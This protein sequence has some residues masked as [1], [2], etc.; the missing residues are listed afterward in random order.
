MSNDEITN[1]LTVILIAM[2]V[3]LFILVVVYLV[4]RIKTNKPQ[5]REEKTKLDSKQ[6]SKQSEI[7]TYNKQSIFSFMKFD[8]IEDNMIVRRNG[9]KFLMLIECQGINYD[10]MSGLEKNSVEQGFLQFLNTLRYPIQ[11]YVQTRTVNL[12]SGIIKYKERVKEI[13]DRLIKKQ[14]E[15]NRKES[16]GYALQ[17]INKARLDVTRERNLYEYGIDIINNTEKMSLNK[18]ILRKHYYVIIDY[19][20]EEINTNSFGKEEI[21]S[22]AFS[23]LYTKAQ[24]IINALAVCGVNGKILNSEELAELL[25]VA[26]NRDESEV[27][28]LEKA[29]NAGYDELYST[30][31]DVLDKRM[32]ELDKKVEYEAKKLANET[33]MEVMEERE[34][35]RRVKQ[36]EAEMDEL[37]R[38]MASYMVE[39]NE[40]LIGK[41]VADAAKSKINGEEKVEEETVKTTTRRRG[42]KKKIT[43]EEEGINEEE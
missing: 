32:K 15:L 29:L 12:E 22:M 30:A 21:S 6:T 38:Q 3:I 18:N 19:V 26:Y 23:E 10:L 33:V 5:K 13:Q 42:R 20:P 43:K 1:L 36:Q 37:I 25:Y 11:I 4:L 27:Y 39:E 8:K 16:L 40:S 9:N 41:D 7:T 24:S 14:M 2:I 17:D 34:N 28:D 31:E 35:A